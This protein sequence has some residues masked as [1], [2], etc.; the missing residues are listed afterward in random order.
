MT[1]ISLD[2]TA[3]KFSLQ[4]TLL[5]SSVI[6]FA[7]ITML[8]VLLNTFPSFEGGISAKDSALADMGNTIV[9]FSFIALALQSSL[10]IFVSNFRALKRN[11]KSRRIDN[12][13]EEI[14]EIKALINPIPVPVSD[15]SSSVE[16]T[17]SSSAPSQPVA[18]IVIL[19]PEQL[20]QKE[21]ELDILKQQLKEAELD[22]ENY[23]NTTKNIIAL[24]SLLAGIVISLAGVRILQPFADI[25][26][27]GKQLSLFNAIDVLLTGGLLAGGSAGVHRLTKVYE[28]VT[29]VSKKVNK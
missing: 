2:K 15:E 3:G 4:L 7:I 20:A 6:F 8:W 12:L 5:F 9:V 25:S 23:R 17:T 29:D 26:L 27:T 16:P 19:S 28:D 14:S 10:G 22:L 11:N 24:L 21:S 18:K 1:D 13:K